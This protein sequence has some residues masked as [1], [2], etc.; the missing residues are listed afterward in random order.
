MRTLLRT[1]ALLVW[2]LSHLPTLLNQRCTSPTVYWI[3]WPV[4]GYAK[5]I[6]NMLG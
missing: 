4:A 5:D 3:P 6:H 1:Y 2:M